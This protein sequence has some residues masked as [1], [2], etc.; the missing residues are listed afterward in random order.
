VNKFQALLRSRKFWAGIIGTALI[1]L[2]SFVPNFPVSDADL[3]KVIELLIAYI[4]GT[5]LEDARKPAK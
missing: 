2:R 4:V 5:G 3:T 1:T